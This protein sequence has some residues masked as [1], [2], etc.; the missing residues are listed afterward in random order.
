MFMLKFRIEI[1][2]CEEGRKKK[3]GIAENAYIIINGLIDVPRIRKGIRK[4]EED[5]ELYTKKNIRDQNF[6]PK[7]MTKQF[8]VE[9]VFDFTEGR[10]GGVTLV[11]ERRIPLSLDDNLESFPYM[12]VDKTLLREKGA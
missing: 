6:P 8:K 10:T 7:T 4:G 5:R 1:L 3:G 12:K 11:N 2:K 9:V